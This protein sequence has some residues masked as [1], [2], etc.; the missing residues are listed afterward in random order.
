MVA[1]TF[2]VATSMPVM[3][4]SVSP[5]TQTVLPSGASV[6]PSGSLP[7]FT[8]ATALPVARSTIVAESASS[9]ETNSLVPSALT[10]NV[11]GS[12]PAGRVL[13]RRSGGDIHDRDAVLAAVRLELLALL[14]RHGRGAL[15]RSAQG[16]VDGLPVGADLHAAGAGAH[17]DRG[18]HAVGGGVDDGEVARILV[19]DVYQL[20][21]R[22][23]GGNARGF[24]GPGR[25]GLSATRQHAG[26]DQGDDGWALD[27]GVLGRGV[28]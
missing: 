17:L 23:G 13:H 7:T 21:T 15:G 26:G 4:W 10:S 14:V 27:H 22:S 24:G 19:G 8:F 2:P 6:T 16:D 12:R 9:F 5:V 28:W 18:D 11:S 3:S 1:I 25:L 20:A